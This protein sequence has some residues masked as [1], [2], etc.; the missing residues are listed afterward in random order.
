MR[1]MSFMGVSGGEEKRI[2]LNE[3]LNMAAQWLVLVTHLCR[4]P[5]VWVPLVLSCK[6]HSS[7][8]GSYH[9]YQ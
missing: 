7:R 5:T 4:L 1:G 8:R 6:L 3:L 2:N 9:F